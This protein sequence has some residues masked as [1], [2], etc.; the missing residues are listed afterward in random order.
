MFGRLDSGGI[1]IL[2][3]SVGFLQGDGLSKRFRFESAE[4]AN[5]LSVS[6]TVTGCYLAHMDRVDKPS[7]QYNLE[8]WP[9]DCRKFG[10][11][12]KLLADRLVF[13]GMTHVQCRFE[14]VT[15]LIGRYNNV[16]ADGEIVHHT[17]EL[18]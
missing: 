1:K 9:L 5:H 3:A 18:K 15:R 17:R 11:T 7:N 12:R 16:R 2:F 14:F 13:W 4:R 8:E 6:F 10:R